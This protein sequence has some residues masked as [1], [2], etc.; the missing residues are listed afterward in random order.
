MDV[1][2]LG[3]LC[4]GCMR[5]KG[6]ATVCPQC[7]YRLDAQ[8][9]PFALPY[10]AV[11][12]NKFLVGRILGKPGGFGVTYLAWDLVLHTTVAVKEY[13][14][15]DL[16][17]RDA[18]NLTVIPHSQDDGKEFTYGLGQF[19]QEARTLGK[20][21][22]PNVVRVKE[23]FQQNNTAYLVMD[24]YEGI[25]LEEYIKRNGGKLGETLAINLMLPI[26]DGLKEV[27][28]KG[29]LHRDIKP[30]NIYLTKGGAPILLD[31]GAARL[32]LQGQRSRPLSVILTPGFAPFEQYLEKNEFGPT[33]DIYAIGATLYY[34]VTGVKPQVATGRYMKDQMVPPHQRIPSLTPRFSQAIMKALAVAPEQRPQTIQELR[35]LLIPL[36]EVSSPKQSKIIADTEKVIKPPPRRSYPCPHCKV[37]NSVPQGISPSRLRCMK[38]GR[39][40]GARPARPLLP[41]WLWGLIGSA[42]L[43][44]GLAFFGRVGKSRAIENAPVAR[45]EP[46]V[47]AST[48]PLW[49]D[50]AVTT[51]APSPPAREEF[52]DTSSPPPFPPEGAAETEDREN[53]PARPPESEQRS[54]R[55]PYPP[56][57][58]AIHMCR[59]KTVGAACELRPPDRPAIQG[60]CEQIRDYFAC[61]PEGPSFGPPPGQ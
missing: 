10:Q 24:Y 42:L 7:G 29:F 2:D 53:R 36:A 49:E 19:L 28:A 15:R 20:F 12:N 17:S 1:D 25:S 55:P 39:S 46:V 11:L 44:W 33:V 48:P 14:P 37:A 50:P 51:P 23:F 34:L 8:R 41:V 47:T 21:S 18:N 35:A 43:V 45:A 57:Q 56:P 61:K 3:N 52:A 60:R 13:L 22:H 58:D 4:M 59:G 54:G 32:A 16:V 5:D 27:H 26:L 31:F 40:L 9:S 30:S 6:N 38:C